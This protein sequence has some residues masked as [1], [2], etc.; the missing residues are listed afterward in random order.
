VTGLDNL[1]A[2]YDTALKHARLARLRQQPGFAFQQ[3]DLADIGAMDTLFGSQRFD[4]VLHLGAQAGVR[5]SLEQPFAYADSNLTG[6]LTVLEGVRRQACH[7]VYASSSSVYGAN[8]RAPFTATDRTDQPISLYAASKKA[9]EVM[10]HAYAHLY[11]VP[12]TG[13]R[14]FTVYGPWG[15]PDMAYF[16]FAE[17]ICAG[18]PIDIYNHGEMARDFTYV[19]DIVDGIVRVIERGP[20]PVAAG[21][22]HRIYNF[23]N[24]RPERLLDLVKHLERLLGH[25]AQLRMLPMQPGDVL[26]T[27]AD[28]TPAM[29]DYGY[30]PQVD[31]AEG[32]ARFVAW[33]REYSPRGVAGKVHRAVIDTPAERTQPVRTPALAAVSHL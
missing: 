17:A 15:R 10:A 29:R 14:F 11:R 3:I 23:G 16:K 28:I 6:M 31:L 21:A 18:R 22:P 12:M 25:K 1:N 13:L 9:G 5:H 24:N 26:S 19:D 32:L 33:Y 7:L 4:A 2:Y 20:L 30:A 27:H 8:P